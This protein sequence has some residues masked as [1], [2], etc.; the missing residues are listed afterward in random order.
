MSYDVA[1]LGNALMDALVV[2]EDEGIIGHLELN[3][4]TSHLVNHESWE[5]AYNAV[6]QLK[7]TFDSGGSCANTIA[8]IGLLGG[9]AIFCGQVGDDQMGKMYASKLTDACGSHA[10]R[11]TDAIPTGK[12][13]SIIAASDAERTMV[14]D[15]GANVVL[16]DISGFH[17]TM[18][19]SKVAHFE[20]YMLLGP[21][22]RAMV[23]E[24]MGHTRAGG[25]LVSLD[26]SDPFVVAAIT[27]SLKAILREHVD[28]VFLN[29]EEAKALANQPADEAVHTI[30]KELG[31]ATVIVKL[32]K[33]G[34][35]V[36]DHG[37]LYTI[38]I[39]E[40]EAVDTTG[41]GD[42]YAGG[43]LFGLTQGW[44]AS[45]SGELAAAVSA[46]TVSQIGAVVKDR[47]ALSKVLAS[48]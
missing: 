45:R 8:T 34:S 20:G 35:L 9:K 21:G 38:G 32:G 1:G 22:T 46:L 12:C 5:E 11:M 24:G 42:A 28:I 40:V 39:R 2:V 18:A 13:L 23:I 36:L 31:V 43:F 14:T 10:L 41:A 17:A 15:L 44:P 7:V 4:G 6:R 3:R 33:R 48:V 29:E 19:N 25:G 30:A 27:D 26:V 47:I 16:N 37:E